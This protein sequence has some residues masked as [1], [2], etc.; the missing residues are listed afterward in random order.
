MYNIDF[1]NISN[2]YIVIFANVKKNKIRI[3]WKL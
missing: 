1:Y 3:L 2:I